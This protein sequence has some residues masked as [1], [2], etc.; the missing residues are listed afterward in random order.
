MSNKN[1]FT[2]VREITH[3]PFRQ[4]PGRRCILVKS[5]DGQFYGMSCLTNAP[6]VH[7]GDGE[8][9]ETAI[10]RV[11]DETATEPDFR[12]FD[13]VVSIGDPVEAMK[14]WGYDLVG[15]P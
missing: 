2:Y 10:L 5:P 7:S 8:I 11:T 15:V 3:D 1:T 12:D 9:T 14:G 6:P 4:G 13:R